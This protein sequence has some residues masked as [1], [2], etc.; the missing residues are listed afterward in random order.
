MQG[1]SSNCGISKNF[2]MINE[3]KEREK[4][5]VFCSRSRPFW[6][7]FWQHRANVSAFNKMSIRNWWK[8]TLI[9]TLWLLL[10][11]SMPT[12]SFTQT[13]D[14]D[15]RIP[16][17]HKKMDGAVE[18]TWQELCWINIIVWN[19]RKFVMLSTSNV[20][21]SHSTNAS[22]IQIDLMA[23]RVLLLLGFC[24]F[25]LCFLDWLFCILIIKNG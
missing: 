22:M 3:L 9:F 11:K 13:G 10:V 19:V 6:N 12:S 8:V 1:K 16:F 4:I 15:S 5:A 20:A 17:Q 25:Y 21:S 23:S 14:T 7:W 18:K 2:H 24:N